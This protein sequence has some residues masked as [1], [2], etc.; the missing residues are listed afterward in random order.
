MFLAKVTFYHLQG[1]TL[2]LAKVTFVHFQGAT[3]FLAKVPEVDLRI[4]TCWS[5]FKCFIVQNFM[6]V[7]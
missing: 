4:E 1:A 2:F 6:Y 3:L 5:D 7:H